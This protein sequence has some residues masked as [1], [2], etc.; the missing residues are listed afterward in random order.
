M[1]LTRS[2]D[3]FLELSERTWI[4]NSSD[5]DAFISIH[6]DSYSRTSRGT[7]T[8]YN[9]SSNFNGPKSEQLAAIVQKHL[10]QQLGTYDRG[11]KTQDFYVNRKNELPSILVELAFISNPNEEALLKTKAFRQKSSRWH[12]RRIGRVFQPIL[13][14]SHSENNS[15]RRPMMQRI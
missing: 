1:K 14:C 13:V 4:A 10:V 8:Y 9:V 5:Y 3:I 11:H 6:A 12:S 2:T 15:M 7:T